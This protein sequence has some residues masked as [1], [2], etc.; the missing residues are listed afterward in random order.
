MRLIWEGSRAL[1]LHPWHPDVRRLTPNQ[2]GWAIVQDREEK[3][4]NPRQKRQEALLEDRTRKA[5][6]L[7][8]WAD[9]HISR[10]R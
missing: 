3:G 8:A 7:V 9:S 5:G 6:E 2:L 1:G 10:R 4:F